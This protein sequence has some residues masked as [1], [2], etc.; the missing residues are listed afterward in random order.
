MSEMR[1]VLLHSSFKSGSDAN[2][3]PGSQR[4]AGSLCQE[5][6]S[7]DSS[8]DDKL[9]RHT[10]LTALGWAARSSPALQTVSNNKEE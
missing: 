8:R 7:P 4:Q 10:S 2:A 6:R 1:A 5:P 9:S 3:D